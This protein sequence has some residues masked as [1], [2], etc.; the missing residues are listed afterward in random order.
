MPSA[1]NQG[2][3][4]PERKAQQPPSRTLDPQMQ[5]KSSFTL[6]PPMQCTHS[7]SFKS[8]ILLVDLLPIRPSGPRHDLGRIVHRA[9]STPRGADALPHQEAGNHNPES[10][11][12]HEVAPVV[13]GLGARVGEI[14]DVVVEHGGGVV[15]DVAVELAEGDDELEGVAHGVVVGDEGGADE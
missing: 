6:H 15:Q 12:E 4:E 2:Y 13:G 11:H 1:Y 8:L 3:S 9:E 5:L 14:V 10:I 7:H